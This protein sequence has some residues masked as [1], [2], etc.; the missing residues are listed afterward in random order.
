MGIG[1]YIEMNIISF[2]LCGILYLKQRGKKL[3]FFEKRSYN[4]IMWLTMIILLLDT[5]SLLLAGHYFHHPKWLHMTALCGYYICQTLLPYQ[6]TRYCI[7]ANKKK[8]NQ[9]QEFI[10]II[11][12]VITVAVAVVNIFNPI[13]FKINENVSIEHLSGFWALCICPL[14]YIF[15]GV[16]LAIVYYINSEDKEI[17]RAIVIFVLIGAI[18]GIIGG[19]F[20]EVSIWPV[21]ALDIVYLHLNVQ[22]KRDEEMSFLAFKD[23]LTGLKNVSA[24]RSTLNK[25]DLNIKE[26]MAEFAVVVMDINGLKLINDRYGHNKGDKLIIHAGKYICNIFQHSPVFRIGG[27]EF[28]AILENRDYNNKDELIRKFDEGLIC[29]TVDIGDISIPLSIARG[30]AVYNRDN[31]MFYSDVFQKADQIMYENKLYLKSKDAVK[32][33]RI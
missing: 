15:F 29:N 23:G 27:D 32:Q 21:I 9:W 22:S 1:A 11:P 31:E 20:D 26:S 4:S 18:A 6:L 30:M 3:Y 17:S 8:L 16:F 28:V 25:L 5:L 33:D 14:T 24:Y 19:L 12:L 13:A 7:H 10:M 2:C